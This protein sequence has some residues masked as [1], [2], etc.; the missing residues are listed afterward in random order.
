MEE[1]V[2]VATDI[3]RPAWIDVCAYLRYRHEPD[4]DMVRRHMINLEIIGSRDDSDS[5]DISLLSVTESAFARGWVDKDTYLLTSE[6]IRYI[7]ESIRL[8]EEE[9]QRD[10]DREY[11]ELPFIARLRRGFFS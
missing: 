1:D 10:K 6:G 8:E 5:A 11:E 2:L 4:I 3:L 7:A 9:I